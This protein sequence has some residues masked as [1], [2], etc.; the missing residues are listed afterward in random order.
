M[1]ACFGQDP[2][3]NI[4]PLCLYRL[5]AQ[6]AWGENIS[7]MNRMVGTFDTSKDAPERFLITEMLSIAFQKDDFLDKS[8]LLKLK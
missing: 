3:K 2:S 1:L 6:I 5:H 4:M 8:K 7:W